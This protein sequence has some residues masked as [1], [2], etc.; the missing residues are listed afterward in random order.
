[1]C[2]RRGSYFTENNIKELFESADLNG[3]GSI[4]INEL[5]SFLN[6]VANRIDPDNKE[7]V[8]DNQLRGNLVC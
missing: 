4:Q 2:E 5:K 6:S 7:E 8:T 3:D 1:M